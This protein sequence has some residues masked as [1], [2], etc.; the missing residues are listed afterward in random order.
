MPVPHRTYCGSS[1][2]M[3]NIFGI[4]PFL[5]GKENAVMT[6]YMTKILHK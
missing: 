5:S 6:E 2:D 3:F 1:S 4:F